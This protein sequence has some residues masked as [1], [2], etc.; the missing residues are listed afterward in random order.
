MN[1]ICKQH[2]DRQK[3]RDQE[4]DQRYDQHVEQLE[5]ENR[6]YII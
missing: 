2:L 6:V 1:R 3:Q 4:I 5:L